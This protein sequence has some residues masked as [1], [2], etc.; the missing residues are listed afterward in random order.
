[1]EKPRIIK[2]NTLGIAD[3]WE[4]V[5][6]LK[7][8]SDVTV[9]GNDTKMFFQVYMGRSFAGINAKGA[10]YAGFGIVGG[11]SYPGGSKIYHDPSISVEAFTLTPGDDSDLPIVK[12]I[13][14]GIAL[15]VGAALFVVIGVVAVG[16]LLA[17]R[18]K[19]SVGSGKDDGEDYYETYYI[20]KKRK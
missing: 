7:W 17:M 12:L 1:M 5:G 15:F 2:K 10:L 16:G 20:E 11:F 8:V 4:K 9:D 3:N 13:I 14:V 19:E 18:R 6:R